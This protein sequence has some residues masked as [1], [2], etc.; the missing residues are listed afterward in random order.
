MVWSS[1]ALLLLLL[2]KQKKQKQ[3]VMRLQG[4]K[5]Y[6]TPVMLRKLQLQMLQLERRPQLTK[7]D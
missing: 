5:E 4:M 1:P 3:R 6:L 2:L 7:K